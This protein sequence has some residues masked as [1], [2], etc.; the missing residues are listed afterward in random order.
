MLVK[1]SIARKEKHG[2]DT[3]KLLFIQ[4][5]GFNTCSYFPKKTVSYPTN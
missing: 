3:V 2:K 5:P 1:N 4:F